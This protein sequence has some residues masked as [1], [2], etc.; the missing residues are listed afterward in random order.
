MSWRL[1]VRPSGATQL[2]DRPGSTAHTA[3]VAS[4]ASKYSPEQLNGAQVL[5]HA[6]LAALCEARRWHSGAGVCHMSTLAPAPRH[7]FSQSSM[8]DLE[9]LVDMSSML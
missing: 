6:C 8:H 7:K 1:L 3:R 9:A 4:H 2:A 5:S